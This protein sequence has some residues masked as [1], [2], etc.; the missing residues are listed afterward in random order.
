MVEQVGR[1]PGQFGGVAPHRL[2]HR[3]DRFLA[4]FLRDLGAAAGK[5]LGGVGGFRSPPRRFRIARYSRSSVSGPAVMPRP[6]TAAPGT[7]APG[8]RP[9][10]AGLGLGDREDAEMED[11]GAST[12][13]AWPMVT[14]STDGPASRR[15][16]GNHR[17]GTAS[18]TARVSARSKPD[19]CRRG[20]S[21]S[22]GFRRRRIRPSGGPCHGIQPGR[23]AAAMGNTSQRPGPPPWRRWRRRCIGCRTATPPRRRIPAARRRVLIDALSAPARS[24][25]LISSTTRTP[26]PTVSGM[27]TCSAVRRTASYNGERLSDEAVM[28]R[29]VSSSAP[30]R[31]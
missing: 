28:S 10:P 1:F 16:R 9:R 19:S 18:A 30:A 23:G 22:A 14:P 3:L 15:R 2:D 5:Q 7:G 17:T 6:R 26:P 12:A 29:K 24:R 27:N 4:Q 8:C 13:L 11:R 25:A 21:M 20:P 31:S